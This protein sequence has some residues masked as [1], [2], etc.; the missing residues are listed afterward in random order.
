[1]A[2]NKTNTNQ[3]IIN[4]FESN[5]DLFND[6]LEE[7]NLYT[8]CVETEVYYPMSSFDEMTNHLN[9][10]DIV[11]KVLE[12]HDEDEV[13]TSFNINKKYFY[14]DFKGNLISTNHR[15]YINDQ[16]NH[17]NSKIIDLMHH[18]YKKG[19]LPMI[20]NNSTLNQLFNLL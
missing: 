8:D 13:N 10:I 15:S 19:L 14:F 16:Y 12:G 3:A 6:A 17:L 18:F 1:M 2:K 7:L 11:K 9:T 20:G 5:I 4:Y